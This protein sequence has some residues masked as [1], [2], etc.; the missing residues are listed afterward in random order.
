MAK[1]RSVWCVGLLTIGI[2][3]AQGVGAGKDAPRPSTFTLWQLPNQ[4]PTQMMSYVIRTVNRKL[5]VVDGG[6]A[7]DAPYLKDF[8]RERGNKVECWL[9]SHMHGDHVTALCEILANREGMEIKEIYVELPDLEWTRRCAPTSE[10]I[11]LTKT[12]ASAQC[13]LKPYKLGA[14]FTID[15]VRIQVLGVG[16]PEITQNAINNSSVVFRMSDEVKSVLFTGDLGAEGGEKL[17]KSEHADALPSDYVQMAH[18]GQ[19]GVTEA[20]YRKVNPS[21]CLW[22][23]PK[24]LWD[25]DKGQGKNSGDWKTLTVRAWMDKFHIKRHYLMF[26]GLQQID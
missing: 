14:V 1:T 10:V 23:T 5:I 26:E 9:I 18:H 6:N 2:A 21:Y 22:P 3:L 4:T 8:I 24:W 20:F 12:L 15:G 19:N 7:G 17:L 13:N 11:G 25:N 16:N